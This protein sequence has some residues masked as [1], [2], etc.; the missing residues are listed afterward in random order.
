MVRYQVAL[1]FALYGYGAFV[2]Y[3]PVAP[4][5]STTVP[6]SG[7]TLSYPGNDST[8]IAWF[9]QIF[10]YN[11]T[12]GLNPLF[13]DRL[14]LPF[15]LHL[16]NVT[17]VPLLAFLSLPITATWGAFASL[18]LLVRLS[19]LLTAWSM[20]WVIRHWT[21]PA[22]AFVAGAIVGFGPFVV[23]QSTL[24]LNLAF[25]ALV[26]LICYAAYRLFVLREGPPWRSGLYLGWPARVSTSF[27]PK[28]W[29]SRSSSSHWLSPATP[30]RR[31]ENYGR[32]FPICGG[33]LS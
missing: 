25:Q 30:L 20:Y 32:R 6:T 31:G 29:P 24:H 4:W 17:A 9:L 11:V 1:Y 2:S 8:V 27:H 15:G 26:P 18:N 21:R 12:H 14:N 7:V 13:T 23:S 16:A 10:S 3:L 28:F 5:S 33:R 22:V 19:F